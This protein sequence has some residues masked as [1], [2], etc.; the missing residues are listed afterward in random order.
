MLSSLKSKDG[1]YC[2]S[3]LCDIFSH[4]TLL[5]CLI[6]KEILRSALCEEIIGNSPEK[7]ISEPYNP[8]EESGKTLL[9]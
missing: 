7:V 8:S 5:F 1:I 9:N 3:S 4:L 6:R 2:S